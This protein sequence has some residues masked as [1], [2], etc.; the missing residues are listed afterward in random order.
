MKEIIPNKLI[1]SYDEEGCIKDAILQYKIKEDG[2]TKNQ[3]YTMTVKD[4]IKDIIGNV[5]NSAKSHAEKGEK[6]K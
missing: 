3:F 5:L 4:G 6:I 2:V 1:V